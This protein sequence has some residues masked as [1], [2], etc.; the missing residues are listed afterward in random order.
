MVVQLKP[1]NREH[2]AVPYQGI[3]AQL[4]A[5]RNVYASKS[6]ESIAFNPRAPV[7]REYVAVPYQ[8]IGVQL[9]DIPLPTRKSISISDLLRISSRKDPIKI[10]SI[11][12]KL[13]L[14][15][16]NVGQL[17]LEY[18]HLLNAL[19]YIDQEP[20]TLRESTKPKQFRILANVANH[21]KILYYNIEM[22]EMREEM[23]CLFIQNK[24]HLVIV[25]KH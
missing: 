14:A 8:G 15:L 11:T 22:L 25:Q 3:G 19:K 17:K 21:Q 24:K 5:S 23:L 6:V 12:R 2:V 20:P 1:V 16:F 18:Y 13:D 4:A 10:I 9:A 7:N